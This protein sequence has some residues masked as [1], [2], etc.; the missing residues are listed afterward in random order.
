ML[1]KPHF[2]TA[3]LAMLAMASIAAVPSAAAAQRRAGARGPASSSFRSSVFVGGGFG[4]PHYFV[5]NPYLYGY[6]YGYQWGPYAPYGPYGPYG[7]YYGR[8]DELTGSLRV[9]VKPRQ[10]QVFVD[11]YAAGIV[12]DYDGIFQRLH[13]QP[14]SHQI[15]LYLQGYRT[16]S[17][18]VYLNPEGDQKIHYNME[19]LAPGEV[20]QAPPAPAD[21]G[22]MA[23][24]P[25]S[26][27]RMP[28]G[29]R[30][31]RPF[32]MGPGGPGGPGPGPGQMGPGPQDL[33]P[34][35]GPDGPD[36]V[37]AQPEPAPMR[38]PQRSFGTLSVRVQPADA[39]ILIDGQVWAAPRGEDRIGIQLAAGRHHVEV[40]KN[41]FARYTEDVLIRAGN[42]LTLNV[43]LT[44]GS[45][46]APGAPGAQ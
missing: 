23:S 13:L 39:E 12:D 30:A 15:V 34:A 42:T 18:N 32:P 6:G 1:S 35:P 4:F 45:A 33:P 21:N 22:P 36:G 44:S 14:G 8:A 10:A 11:G 24:G 40:Q 43:S 38:Q 27:D 37:T 3:L 19:P 28:P 25:S 16:V 41:G 31:G 29:L 7:G 46:G 5:Y 2:K 26:A 20:S 9:E 17:Q